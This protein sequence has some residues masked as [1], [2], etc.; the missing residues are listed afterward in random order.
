VAW[1][2]LARPAPAVVQTAVARAAAAAA[3]PVLDATGDV[4]AR[5]QATVSAKIT[6]KVAAVLIEEGMRVDEGAAPARR[7][8]VT[9]AL[10]GA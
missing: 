6:G 2:V 5:R 1:L 3:A 8:P 9:E 4:T 7:V 10:R